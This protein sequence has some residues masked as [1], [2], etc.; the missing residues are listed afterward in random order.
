[1]LALIFVGQ[2]LSACGGS[3]EEAEPGTTSGGNG[4]K[5]AAGDGTVQ[6]AVWVTGGSGGAGGHDADAGG[7]GGVGGGAG[8]GPS[9]GSGGSGGGASCQ[10][11]MKSGSESDVDCGGSCPP[12]PLGKTC[13]SDADCSSNKCAQGKCCTVTSYEATTGD[14][15]GTGDVCCNS[16]DS[17]TSWSDCATGANHGVDPVAPNCAHA[18]EGAGNGGTAC[19]KIVCEKITCN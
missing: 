5:D 3:T 9:G 6:D 1:M 10:D 18:W 19:A 14:V 8:G 16:G 17:R 11:G 15:S 7:A 2:P 13:G 12:C 4:G